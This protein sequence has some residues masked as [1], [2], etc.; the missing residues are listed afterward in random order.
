MAETSQG[1]GEDELQFSSV[2]PV[3]EAAAPV[4]AAAPQCVVCH[5]PI[6]DVYYA[7]ADKII[8]PPCRDQYEAAL[9]GGSKFG[10]LA[11]A[12]GLG[13]AAGL[14]G[15]AV[16]FGIRKISGAPSTILTRWSGRCAARVA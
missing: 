8:C 7:A 4:A 13:I 6:A 1:P 12:T 10:R 11:A 2:E 15:A 3:G 16:W 5:R 14:L 9:K